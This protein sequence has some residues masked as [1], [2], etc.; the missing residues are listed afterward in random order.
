MKPKPK[1]TGRGG[2]GRGQGRKTADGATGVQQYTVGL[3]D[4]SYAYYVA[5]GNGELS[6]GIR[7]AWKGNQYE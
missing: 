2:A 4:E 5:V 3:D 7:K 6:A 1:L